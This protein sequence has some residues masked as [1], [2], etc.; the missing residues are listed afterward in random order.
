MVRKRVGARTALRDSLSNILNYDRSS[1]GLN[2]SNESFDIIK[3]GESLG[4]KLVLKIQELSPRDDNQKSL[5]AQALST[6]L[7]LGQTRWLI[8]EQNV[9]PVPNLLLYM[10]VGWL[11]V[12]FLSFGIFAPRNVTVLIGLC[13]AASAVCGAI[14]LILE[15]Y[16]PQLGLIR[17]SDAPLRA[18]LERI[19]H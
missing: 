19:G 10:L 18:A 13:M 14:L 12:L 1:P 15:M 16:H 3:S 6:V 9:V 7:Q 4:G 8:F 17:I 2:T 5:K 11:I